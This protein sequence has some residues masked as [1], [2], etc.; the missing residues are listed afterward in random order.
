MV[1]EAPPTLIAAF[2][3]AARRLRRVFA[4]RQEAFCAITAGAAQLVQYQS[5]TQTYA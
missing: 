4:R 5:Q 1:I 2:D 3:A